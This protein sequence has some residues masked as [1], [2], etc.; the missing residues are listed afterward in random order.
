MKSQSQVHNRLR[1]RLFSTVACTALVTVV[2]PVHS[3]A[4]D[5]TETLSATA[6]PENVA[7]TTEIPTDHLAAQHERVSDVTERNL[8]DYPTSTVTT[9]VV[10]PRTQEDEDAEKAVPISKDTDTVDR[11]ADAVALRGY[12]VPA[13]SDTPAD[14]GEFGAAGNEFNRGT[15]GKAIGS[16]KW[17]YVGDLQ[18]STVP[19]G[20]PYMYYGLGINDATGEIYATSNAKCRTI[21]GF[22]ICLGGTPAVF[23]Y[24]AVNPKAGQYAGNGF[25]NATEDSASDGVGAPVGDGDVFESPTGMTFQTPRGVYVDSTSGNVWIVDSSRNGYTQF[26]ADG[27]VIQTYKPTG[28]GALTEPYGI[29]AYGDELFVTSYNQKINVYDKATGEFKRS[30]PTAQ[31]PWGMSIDQNTGNIY[32]AM[33][34]YQRSIRVF[35]QQGNRLQDI[36]I[37]TDFT[38]NEDGTITATAAPM[39]DD[40]AW[41][42]RGHAFGVTFD[43]ERNLIIAWDQN[44]QSRDAFKGV[45]DAD[46]VDYTDDGGRIWF[47]DATTGKPVDVLQL[48]VDNLGNL[49]NGS[50]GKQ[51]PRGVVMDDRGLVYATTQQWDGTDRD[52]RVI[53]RVQIY[54][55]TPDPVTDAEATMFNRVNTTQ[56]TDANGSLIFDEQGNPVMED[57][58]ESIAQIRW[59]DPTPGDHQTDLKDIVVEI[60]Y[61][62]GQSWTQYSQAAAAGAEEI[63]VA[64]PDAVRNKTY[65]FRLTPF[66]EAGSGDPVIVAAGLGETNMHIN[67]AAQL[68][69]ANGNGKADAGETI[70]YTITVNTDDVLENIQVTD[71]MF[72]AGSLQCNNDQVLNIL[73]RSETLTCTASHTVTAQDVKDALAADSLIHN[74]ATATADDAVPTDTGKTN[75]TGDPITEKLKLAVADSAEVPV[76]EEVEI[77]IIP[78]PIPVPDPFT[79]DQPVSPDAPQTPEVAEVTEKTDAPQPS[80]P[81]AQAQAPAAAPVRKMLAQTGVAGMM[82]I[83]AA[84]FALVAAGVL[85]LRRESGRHNGQ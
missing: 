82:G 12:D 37:P 59:V 52:P 76:A 85:V 17:G 15:S 28:A 33:H 19:D 30:I 48:D 67:K 41:R 26:D 68:V 11:D 66:N 78:L 34:Q 9:T 79:P 50:I 57:Q 56:A 25:F 27:N 63:Y 81:A 69:D 72:D 39:G 53:S 35:D 6:G 71:P 10:A 40:A 14:P 58:V 42:E 83:S 18:Q 54:G 16:G 13:A 61:D 60:S 84:A 29:D 47:F 65:Y 2:L 70:N 8:L 49:W 4:Q 31:A 32:V 51:S 73:D 45:T 24:D 36:V 43:E 1:R 44:G 46:A 75:S 23:G 38:R 55:K 5:V 62:D 7:P 22:D 3:F 20:R 77:P 64:V 74:T 80:A 21:F